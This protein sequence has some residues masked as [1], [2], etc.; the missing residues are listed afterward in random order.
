MA[1]ANRKPRMTDSEI[2]R[3]RSPSLNTAMRIWNTP[4]RTPS[5]NS[6]SN[7][8]VRF[9]GSMNASE[10][11]TSSEIALVGPLT[12]CE[13]DPNTEATKVTTIDEYTPNFGST[14]ATNAYVMACGS[15]TAATVSPA[16]R[17]RRA[18]SPV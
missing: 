17:S 13:D 7:K 8:T 16:I 1:A 10:L 15:D 2:Y 18:L 5:R 12:R 6:A 4:T 9:S 11:N 3:V 14:P